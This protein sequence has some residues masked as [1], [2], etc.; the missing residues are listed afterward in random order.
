MILTLPLNIIPGQY[1]Y[2]FLVRHKYRFV[3]YV[4]YYISLLIL[5]SWGTIY[6]TLWSLIQ[7]S[8]SASNSFIYGFFICLQL[9]VWVTSVYTG[10]HVHLLTSMPYVYKSTTMPSASANLVTIQLHFRDLQ[11]RCSVLKVEIIFCI[12]LKREIAWWVLWLCIVYLIILG[13]KNSEDGV[14]GLFS[15]FVTD[16]KCI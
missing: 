12:F 8:I 10:R 4:S 5:C 13:W 7:P 14:D 1:L 3:N 11:R 9:C 16:G 2:A 15:M 6:Q